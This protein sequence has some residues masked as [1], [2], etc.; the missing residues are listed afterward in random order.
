M[1]DQFDAQGLHGGMDFARLR[2]SWPRQEAYWT[3]VAIVCNKTVATTTTIPYDGLD[4][5]MWRSRCLPE[6]VMGVTPAAR[7][8]E[9]MLWA[10]TSLQFGLMIEVCGGC[11]TR[12]IIFDWEMW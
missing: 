5:I 2:P 6:G 11:R 12:K 1:T 4:R 9:E 7:V 3:S 10:F 8:A